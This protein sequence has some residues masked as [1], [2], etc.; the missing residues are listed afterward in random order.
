VAQQIVG[1]QSKEEALKYVDHAFRLEAPEGLGRFPRPD[2]IGPLLTRLPE[3]LQDAVRM[4][5]LNSSRAKGRISDALKSAAEVR[6]VGVDSDGPRG[7]LIT[8]QAPR[9]GDAAPELFSQGKFW[10][11]G[12]T[13]N[14]TAFDL[15][16]SAV[17]DVAARKENSHHFDTP[18]LR[19]FSFF[20]TYFDRGIDR[21]SLP[22]THGR[23]ETSIDRSVVATARELSRITPAPRRVRV[24]GRLDLMGASQGVLKLHLKSGQIIT[25]LWTGA[26]PIEQHSSYF[27]R[28]VVI[29]GLG[30]FR[31]SGILLRIDAD[32]LVPATRQDDFFREA[33]SA[34]PARDYS[35]GARLRPDEGSAYAKLQGSVPAEESDE[36]FL[37]ALETLR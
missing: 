34:T 7:T 28:E 2:L 23:N 22:G 30:V 33:P 36:V 27:N 13:A 31:T 4:G 15:L 3:T 9:F 25:A 5:F 14:D 1:K 35:K 37:A 16:D 29:E 18:F 20:G 32:A 10:D 19:R 6:F 17:R 24:A 21:I 11:E 26:E 12:P 8:F